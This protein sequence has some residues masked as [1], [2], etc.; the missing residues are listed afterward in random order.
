MTIDVRPA[1]E[2]GDAPLDDPLGLGIDAGGRL[3][4]DQDLGIAR[5]RAGEGHQLAL[6]GREVR[7]P[8][9]HRRVEPSGR[10]GDHAVGAHPAGGGE[11]PLVVEGGVAEADVRRAGCPENMKT[12]WLTHDDPAPQRPRIERPDVGAAEADR[13]A[14]GS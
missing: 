4:E 10:R 13:A 6:A 1:H 7:A 2:L 5:Q 3:V 8:L 11:D 14:C 12:S 9:E